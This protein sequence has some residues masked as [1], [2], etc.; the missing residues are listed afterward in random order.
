MSSSSNTVRP[1]NL[2][3]PT[4]YSSR[5]PGYG[6]VGGGLNEPPTHLGWFPN[7]CLMEMSLSYFF[8]R[9]QSGQVIRS[10]ASW[11]ILSKVTFCN[12]GN[13]REPHH[14]QFESWCHENSWTLSTSVIAFHL[15]A[16]ACIST[17]RADKQL[18][19]TSSN[20]QT[21]TRAVDSNEKNCVRIR[22]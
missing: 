21:R 16:G 6:I 19:E 12:F 9:A 10:N 2:R 20:L 5:W 11:I 13:G 3:G 7:K 18:R 4:C 17:R 1:I 22:L 15:S 14:F 8:L